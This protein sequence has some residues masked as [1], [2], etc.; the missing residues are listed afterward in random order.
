MAQADPQG[1]ALLL[2]SAPAGQ[3]Q[4]IALNLVVNGLAQDSLTGAA[5][6][7]LGLGDDNARSLAGTLRR[8]GGLGA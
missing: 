3:Q 2:G 4:G 7:A 1:A 6:W 8:R 5:H